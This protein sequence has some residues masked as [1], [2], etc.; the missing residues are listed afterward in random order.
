VFRLLSFM[1]AWFSPSD[2]P[3]GV[4]MC[5]VRL[6]SFPSTS[7]IH[8]SPKTLLLWSFPLYG[9]L[10]TNFYI[11]TVT[12]PSPLNSYSPPAPFFCEFEKPRH[13][14]SVSPSICA[15]LNKRIL[16]LVFREKS[17]CEFLLKIYP[18]IPNLVDIG[19]TQR[20]C[21]SCRIAG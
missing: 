10:P 2:V 18:H 19:Q 4:T 14:P 9:D 3:R 21:S 8:Y 20:T 11:N 1:V 15:N 6:G 12:R 7:A 13:C 16:S 5:S 17:Y